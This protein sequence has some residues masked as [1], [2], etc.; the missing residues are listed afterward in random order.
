MSLPH[1]FAE[2]ELMHNLMK[3]TYV[4]SNIITFISLFLSEFIWI[5]IYV[6]PNY[7]LA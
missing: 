2:E 6:D 3:I 5:T 4:W 1:I 7:Y